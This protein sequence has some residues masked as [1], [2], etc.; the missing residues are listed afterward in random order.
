LERF[1]YVDHI[2][3]AGDIKSVNVIDTLKKIAPVTAV[4][5]NLDSPELN[6]HLRKKEILSF[7]KYHIGVVHGDGQKGKTVARAIN[8]FQS[9]T[10]DCII[11][12]HSHNP[13]IQ[14]YGDTL[15]FNPGSPTLKRRNPYYSFGIIEIDN[16]TIRPCIVYFN[17]SEVVMEKSAPTNA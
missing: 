10:V 1:H 8:C 11:F 14:Y 15:L 9:D 2:I 17:S 7:H 12:G 16:K 6:N 13:L 4:S 3:H 5:G